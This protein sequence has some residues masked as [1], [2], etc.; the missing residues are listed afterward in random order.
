M[1]FAAL[2]PEV[3]SGLM[4]TGAGPGPMISAATA[5]DGLAAELHLAAT[6]YASVVSE[7]TS[8]PWLGPSSTA[9]VA[10][11]TPFVS[12][13]NAT[14]AQAEK[15]GMQAKA[16]VAAYEATFA[17]VVPP[18]VIAANR[19]ALMTLL[20]TNIL[21]QN[22]AAIAANE[23]QYAEMW[24]QDATAMYSYASLSKSAT[25]LEPFQQP[26][27]TANPAGPLGQAAALQNAAGNSAGSN[28]QALPSQL[29]ATLQGAGPAQATPPVMPVQAEP[30]LG[31]L[32]LLGILADE[33]A[34]GIALPLSV[35][36]FP[37]SVI[38]LVMAVEA[39]YY[40]EL[41]SR[42]ILD[43][44]DLLYGGQ[45]NIL[46]GLSQLGAETRVPSTENLRVPHESVKV[47]QSFPLGALSV[48]PNWVEAAPEIRHASFSTPLSSAAGPSPAGLGTA[49]G[50]MALA[51]MGGSALAGAVNQNRGQQGTPT[52]A[53]ESKAP[54]QS[55]EAPSQAAAPAAQSPAIS[56][57]ELAAGIRELGQLHD[58]GYLTEAEFAEQK[59]RLLS[60]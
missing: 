58:A 11:I 7:L 32:D 52:P 17:T 57:I 41:D 48:P 14:S 47:G 56:V 38:S 29:A 26:P 30:P 31:L 43:T 24:A 46:D 6:A 34:L 23:A 22:A 50:Q 16:A 15:T 2:P 45:Q 5:W 9:M 4:Y 20:A 54:A 60:R 35:V 59:Q 36:A 10:S 33:T 27:Q 53:A 8:G 18:P 37:L 1:D 49:F 12:W 39:A 40:A 42:E 19:A 28:A 13:L 25:A 55:A 51:G 21:G 3:I 44:Q